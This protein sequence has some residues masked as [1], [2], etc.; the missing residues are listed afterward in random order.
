M[1][2]LHWRVTAAQSTDT[3]VL[4]ALSFDADINTRAAVAKNRATPPSALI[5]LA[6]DDSRHVALATLLN[7]SLPFNVR[8]MVVEVTSD[9]AMARLAVIH[10][11]AEERKV[12]Q[13]VMDRRAN[14][15]TKPVETV[16]AAK[17]RGL[18]AESKEAD[19]TPQRLDELSREQN[20]VVRRNVAKH[21]NTGPATLD[22]LASD[23]DRRVRNFVALNAKTMPSTRETIAQN[24]ADP[25]IVRVVVALAAAADKQAVAYAAASS[26][27][28]GIA[29]EWQLRIEREAARPAP[30]KKKV[31][32]PT[33]SKTAYAGK[34]DSLG[35]GAYAAR[36]IG[37]AI[38]SYPCPCG[39]WHHT[40][41]V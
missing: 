3:D 12:L 31:K 32:C 23:M 35:K 5:R 16:E 15:L 20:V 17:A 1:E 27:H 9:F 38:R 25:D 29:A 21:L 4:N 34:A 41:Q 19:A 33:P 39:S 22:F 36:A 30:R 26:I 10:A 40:T 11:P 24:E 2:L 7:K 28:P 8:Q 13:G 18:I 6:G 14:E 37:R